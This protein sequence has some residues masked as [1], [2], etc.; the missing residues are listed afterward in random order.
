MIDNR[1]IRNGEQHPKRL[2]TIPFVRTTVTAIEAAANRLSTL[3]QTHEIIPNLPAHEL[4]GSEQDA[5]AIQASLVTKM[6]D[7]RGGHTIGY[8]VACTS[9]HAQTLL[10]VDGP[11]TGRMLS[12][13]TTPSPGIF[14]SA[15]FKQRVIEPEFAFVVSDPPPVSATPYDAES[16]R[17]YLGDFLP[18]I[19]IVDHHYVDFTTVGYLSLIA[20]NA[21]H[22]ACVLGAPVSDWQGTDLSQQEV[23]LSVNGEHYDT[24]S[25]GNVL[26]HPLTVMAWLT[27]DLHRRG[28]NFHAGDIVVTGVTTKTYRA[29]R[30]DACTVDFGAL[31]SVSVRF[32]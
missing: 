19:E 4:P 20:D 3:R 10:N 30:G 9:E 22:G 5:Y 11:F 18:A 17:R 12:A 15:D 32:A 8:K 24:G 14:T 2:F 23:H 27:N 25:G 31:G 6:L 28:E 1:F 21:I 26:G 16:I 29:Q 13:T 7:R